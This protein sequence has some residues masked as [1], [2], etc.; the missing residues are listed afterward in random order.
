MKGDTTCAATGRTRKKVLVR[1]PGDS[2][3]F[4]TNEAAEFGANVNCL[5]T[6]KISETCTDTWIHCDRFFLGSGE[7]LRVTGVDKKGRV[8]FKKT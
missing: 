5:V 4:E 6:Y 1:E 2:F 3:I 7:I 8:G